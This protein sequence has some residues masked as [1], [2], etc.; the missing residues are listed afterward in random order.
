MA[1]GIAP[2][3]NCGTVRGFARETQEFPSAETAAGAMMLPRAT[4]RIDKPPP[5]VENSIKWTRNSIN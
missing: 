1:T 4:P 3:C 2:A 5:S